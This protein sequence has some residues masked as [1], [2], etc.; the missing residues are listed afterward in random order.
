MHCFYCLRSFN[1]NLFEI[2][3]FFSRISQ[4]L[5]CKSV[6][7]SSIDNSSL[8]LSKSILKKE[9][10]YTFGYLNPP[11]V[12]P[13]CVPWKIEQWPSVQITGLPLQGSNPLGSSKVDS[14]I[15]SLQGQ[16]DEYQELLGLNSKKFAHS[17][18]AVLRH[19]KPIHIS[20]PI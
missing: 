15:S 7:T 2:Q 4:L 13:Q 8:F 3:N 18:S 12:A 20:T 9:F 5:F 1:L 10:Q 6:I 17:G 16:S 11:N 19:F 14:E